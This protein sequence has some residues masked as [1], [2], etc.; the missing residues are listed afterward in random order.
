MAAVNGHHRKHG[1]PKHR[2]SN[3]SII[4]EDEKAPTMFHFTSKVRS[5]K[6]GP[7]GRKLHPLEKKYLL[8]AEH[9]D[10]PTVK[11][12]ADIS[13]LKGHSIELD[14]NCADSLGR[15]AVHMAIENEN[16]PL[17]ETL[18]EAHVEVQDSLLHAINAEYVEA[19]EL[20][21]DHEEA[22]HVEGEPYN[23][24]KVNATTTTFNPEITPLILAAHRNNYE[25]LKLLLD[26][27]ATLPMPHDV[28]C[29]CDQCVQEVREDCLR[30]SRSRI[31]AYRALSSPSLICLS[32]VDPILTAFELS[33]ELKRLSYVENEFKVEY[34]KLQRQC[35]EFATSLL[36]HIRTSAELAC[37]MNHDMRIRDVE[38]DDVLSMARLELAIEHQ[39]KKFVAHPNVQQQM[40]SLWYDGV[41][42]FRRKH[43]VGQCLQII[44]IGAVFPYY[45]FMYIFFPRSRAGKAAKRPFVKFV[46]NA[47]S[48]LIFLLLL[49]LASQRVNLGGLHTHSSD[50]EVSQHKQRG[51]PPSFIEVAILTYVIAQIWEEATEIWSGGLARYLKDSWNTLDSIR[52]CLYVA[53]TLLRIVAYIQ[54]RQEIDLE[55]LLEYLPREHW[56]AFDPMLVAEG[57]FAAGN[58]FSALRLVH[59]FS[60]NPHLGPLQISLG[61][62]VID[63]IKFFFIYTLVLFSFACGLNQL[64]WYY[65]DLERSNCDPQ[66]SR[67]SACLTWRRFS[68]LFESSQ[69]LF[70]ASFGL[71]DLSNFELAGIKS[72]TRFWGLLMF[73]SYSVIN[74][75]VLL[76][77]LI[78]MMSN[79]FQTISERA[80]TEWKFGRAKLILKY[81]QPGQTLPPPFNLLEFIRHITKLLSC[82]SGK[83]RKDKIYLGDK[84]FPAKKEELKYQDVMKSLVWRYVTSEQS[85]NEQAPVTED[86]VN[87]L[88][89]Q[90]TS[91][92]YDLLDVLK[93]NGMK[94]TKV[95]RKRAEVA[96]N[97]KVRVR[98]RRLL[99][100][101][102]ITLIDASDL[103]QLSRGSR[104]SSVDLSKYEDAA[105]SESKPS[106][107]RVL[108]RWRDLV[109]ALQHSP[110]GTSKNLPA[111]V[112]RT[113]VLK[114]RLEHQVSTEIE[115]TGNVSEKKLERT[116]E[117]GPQSDGSTDKCLE[118]KVPQ[119]VDQGQRDRPATNT[120]S[121]TPLL[122]MVAGRKV[123]DVVVSIDASQPPQQTKLENDAARA[124]ESRANFAAKHPAFSGSVKRG[125]L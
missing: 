63:I 93:D 52:N 74:I 57:L 104:S 119:P 51:Q 96:P 95:Q 124:A 94:V 17:L 85:K 109:K 32:S 18:L 15:T 110:I 11:R 111:S 56:E 30:H 35:Q 23:W 39:Q 86:D 31:N 84:G 101:F 62:M 87:E 65:A 99:K 97:K 42:G 50:G 80:D 33:L 26:R 83:T 89:Q 77:L 1:Q 125:W 4:S 91:F 78:A 44:K 13:K 5:L 46:A 88:K 106:Y 54:A 98:E 75:V 92:R 67:D 121:E 58:V 9:G 45:S 73:G 34:K 71:V 105:E 41:P 28:R 24:E 38:E 115:E 113:S 69:S 2:D 122:E 7:G 102:S 43:I 14:M 36:D 108:Q 60:M 22:T 79:S 3:M 68:N 47:F 82:K 49:I 117:E 100:D 114:E 40:S 20:L 8:A 90:I 25:I 19:V 53:A 107:S 16:L 123:T 10:I 72:Y 103:D 64:L 118:N 116:P 112:T 55:P 37:I 66:N 81:F 120:Q 21:L 70:W 59:L 29:G 6:H 76:N 27:G 61:R 48:Y 12:I